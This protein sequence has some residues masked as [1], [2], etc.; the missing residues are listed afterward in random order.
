[1]AHRRFRRVRLFAVRAQQ[2]V[3]LDG[4]LIEVRISGG[5]QEQP[6]RPQPSV[7]A[8]RAPD[9]DAEPDHRPRALHAQELGGHTR[10]QAA[11]PRSDPVPG[12]EERCIGALLEL[13]P[14]RLEHV[15]GR[16]RRQR[17]RQSSRWLRHAFSPPNPFVLV[18]RVVEPLPCQREPAAGRSILA[19]FGKLK[20][21][22][23]VYFRVT[24]LG[25]SS[26]PLLLLALIAAT[27]IGSSPALSNSPA[28]A[29][30][31]YVATDGA[32]G[33]AGDSLEK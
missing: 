25:L 19:G 16:Q 8:H 22:M 12:L 32:D 29:K 26:R 21:R 18:R 6:A 23:L 30:T 20:R 3:V 33:N 11:Q 27:P 15:R 1:M 5:V 17:H 14:E 4:D 24:M 7:P 2:P 31:Y 13:T 9:H 28:A 10:M